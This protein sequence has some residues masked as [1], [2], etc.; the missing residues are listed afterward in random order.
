MKKLIVEADNKLTQKR[1]TIDQA[2]QDLINAE[3]VEDH[4][5]IVANAK[6]AITDIDAGKPI[7]VPVRKAPKQ[8][9]KLTDKELAGAYM[10]AANGDKEVARKLAKTDG[11]S[12]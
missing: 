12:F 4:R 2:N 1:N 8:G 11:W 7:N 6:K 5:K 10:K 9:D 3:S